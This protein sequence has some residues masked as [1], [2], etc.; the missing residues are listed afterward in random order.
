MLVSLPLLYA[1]SIGPAVVLAQRKVIS[2]SVFELAYTPL[3]RFAMHTETK[4]AFIAYISMW[5]TMTGT[6]SPWLK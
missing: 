1:L 3:D 6:P 2:Q 4:D 5:L